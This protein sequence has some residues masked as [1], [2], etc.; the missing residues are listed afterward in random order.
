MPTI[1]NP[2]LSTENFNRHWDEDKYSN[3]RSKFDFYN[4]K[5]N[6]AYKEAERNESVKKWRKLF[7]DDFGKPREQSTNSSSPGIVTAATPTIPATRPYASY[8]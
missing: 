6:E 5:I 8:D 4:T 3:F 2:V 1:H 7:G